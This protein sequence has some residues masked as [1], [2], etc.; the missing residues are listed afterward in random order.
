[1]KGIARQFCKS[2]GPHMALCTINFISKNCGTMLP[3]GIE[4]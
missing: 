1:M 3:P 2:A 4:E